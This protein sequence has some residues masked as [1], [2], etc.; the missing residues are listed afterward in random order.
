MDNSYCKIDLNKNHEIL[1][2]VSSVCSMT[3]YYFTRRKGSKPVR[4][5]RTLS[6]FSLKDGYII[7]PRGWFWYVYDKLIDR[8]H[9]FEFTDSRKPFNLNPIE[10]INLSL[11]DSQKEAID[12]GV[13]LRYGIFSHVTGFG[14]SILAL[15]LISR[16]G[17][18]GLIM[19]PSK[20][21]LY[22][23]KEYFDNHLPSVSLGLIGDGHFEPDNDITVGIIDSLFLKKKE[24][25]NYFDSDLQFLIIDEG[26]RIR[27]GQYDMKNQ[28]FNIALEV[29]SQIKIALTA[30]PGDVGTI[31]RRLLEGV[32]GGVIHQIDN[33][34]AKD[35]GIIVGM[36]VYM[37]KTSLMIYRKLEYH[38]DYEEN[39]LKNDILQSNI[40]KI[41]K[42]TRKR[43]LSLLI[44]CDRVSKQLMILHELIDESVILYGDTPSEDRTKIIQDFE[45]GKFNVLI[46]T[47]V[48]EGVNIKNIDVIILASGGKDS[49]ALIQKIGRGLRAKPGKSDLIFIDFNFDKV[50]K[51]SGGL[52][53]HSLARIK[54]YKR[55]GYEVNDI[56]DINEIRWK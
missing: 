48:K 12:I 26:H 27:E 5:S 13:E 46:S 17:V 11:Y 15:G 21:L 42:E 47:I 53:S 6:F 24:L 22:Q 7:F 10:L 43:G 44:I 39:L 32:T 50:P 56:T 25:K 40:I 23:F 14:K 38:I 49:D 20:L 41:T 33:K 18:P 55:L 2:V 34:K 36:T 4:K 9:T 52:H 30:T 54:T 3:Q 31:K 45:D 8:G 29:N 28:Y 1:G 51:Y 16:V 19:V 35:L 37:I